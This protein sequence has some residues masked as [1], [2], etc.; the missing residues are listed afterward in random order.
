MK[1]DYE[2]SC[3]ECKII[4]E[5]AYKFGNPA[6]KT[7]CPLCGKR[8]EQN[9]LNREA[10]SVHFKGAGW[11]QTTG[12]NRSGGSDEVNKKLQDHCTERME[13]GWQNYAKYDPSEGFIKAAKARRLSDNEVKRGLDVSKKLSSHTYN[14]ARID[15]TK[16]IK[17]Q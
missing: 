14:K 10:P 13:S 2:Y 8:C 17:P 7:K 11:T 12:Y 15:P 3:S 6:D 16:K 5:K 4:W 1:K 9:W